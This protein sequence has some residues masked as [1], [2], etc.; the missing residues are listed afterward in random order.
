[1]AGPL[2]PYSVKRISP[3]FSASTSR[4]RRRVMRAVFFTPFRERG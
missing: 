4:P 2:T 1:M 3:W